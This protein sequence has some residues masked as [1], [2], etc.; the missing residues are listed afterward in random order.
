HA[1]GLTLSVDHS[2]SIREERAAL[3]IGADGV[4]STLRGLALPAARSRDTGY[5]AWRA[6]LRPG[7]G[8][9]E[10]VAANEVTA[11]LHPGFHLVAY[12]VRAGEAINLVAVTR[13]NASIGW[14]NDAS[15]D[16]LD[17][18]MEGTAPAL[19]ALVVEA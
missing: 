10:I 5:I 6:M 16:V 19:R 8:T 13:G 7:R 12:P 15:I 11:F 1:H 17:A 18:A 4:W 14:N 9:A 2:G 3:V